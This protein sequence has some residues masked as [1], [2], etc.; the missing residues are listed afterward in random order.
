MGTKLLGATRL[1]TP[2][3]KKNGKRFT[4][5]HGGGKAKTLD[6]IRMQ[7]ERCKKTLEESVW[8]RMKRTRNDDEI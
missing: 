4:G 5:M 2:Y 6:L 1:D 8:E 3:N 7:N